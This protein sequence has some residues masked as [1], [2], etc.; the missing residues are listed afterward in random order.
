VSLMLRVHDLYFSYG[1]VPVLNGISFHVREG[2]LCGLF[3][4]NGSG[5]TTLFKCCLNFLKTKQGTVHMCGSDISKLSIREMAKIV[6]YVPQEHK[7]PFP[8]LVSEVVLMGRTPH[9]GGVFG[10]PR[11]DKMIA[12][13]ALDTLGIADLAE[14]PYSQL[15]GGQRQMVLMARAIAQ[16]TPLMFLDEPTSALDFQNQMRIWEIMRTIVESGR[17]I[18]ACSHDPNHVSWFCDRVIVIGN[19]G[20]IADG[21]PAKTINEQTLGQIYQNACTVQTVE[22]VRIVMPAGLHTWKNE[23]NQSHT[24]S[25]HVEQNTIRR[26]DYDIGHDKIEQ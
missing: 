16:D 3:G 21:D 14:R 17:T 26:I 23:K 13:D 5:K 20:I 10:I 6:A 15:S 2:E 25:Q 19:G 22:G 1:S 24:Y 7:P 8:Y 4:P 11:R 12:I 9:L 18:I